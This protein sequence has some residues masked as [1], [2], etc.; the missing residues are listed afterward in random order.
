MEPGLEARVASRKNALST[1]ANRCQAVMLGW[2][3][4]QLGGFTVLL[5]VCGHSSLERKLD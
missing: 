1:E 3:S 5:V 4:A 2:L